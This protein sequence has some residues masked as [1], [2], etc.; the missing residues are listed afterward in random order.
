MTHIDCSELRAIP[1]LRV[2]DALGMALVPRGAGV[3]ALREDRQ[4]TSLTVFEKTNS[5]YRFSGKTSGGVSGGS[6]I[7]LVM[8]MQDC[9]FQTA[10]S[11]LSQRFP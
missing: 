3:Y 10:I 1:I 2:A 8:H 6:P 5:W 7:D 9:P 11:F 4:I